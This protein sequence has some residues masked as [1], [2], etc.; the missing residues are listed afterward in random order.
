MRGINRRHRLD[1]SSALAS[2]RAS[3]CSVLD[4]FAQLEEARRQRP[5]T[6]LGSMARRQ[7]KVAACATAPVTILGFA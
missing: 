7:R 2:S 1:L 6:F 3:R 4:A 5:E